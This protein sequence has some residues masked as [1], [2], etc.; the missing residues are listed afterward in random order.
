MDFYLAVYPGFVLAKLQ[1]KLRKKLALMGA[2]G[3]GMVGTVV[4]AYKC[5]RLKALADPDFTCTTTPAFLGK[6]WIPEHQRCG[7]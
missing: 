5:T 6:P 4:A 3:I 7:D 2:L 1:M